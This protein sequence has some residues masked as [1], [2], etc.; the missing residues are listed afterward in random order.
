MRS[1]A[2]SASVVSV[3]EECSV[4]LNVYV[5]GGHLRKQTDSHVNLEAKSIFV[6]DIL[7]GRC[8]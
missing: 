4:I 5:F 3:G 6:N 8:R 1:K 7:Q 2:N